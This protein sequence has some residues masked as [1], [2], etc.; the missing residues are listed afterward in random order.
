MTRHLLKISLITFA[1]ALVA[2]PL[3]AATL[4]DLTLI[5]F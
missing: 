1:I 5:D 4:F 2:L 3:S